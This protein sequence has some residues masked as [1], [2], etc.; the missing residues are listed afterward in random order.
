M[1]CAE[2]LFPGAFQLSCSADKDRS[3]ASCLAWC[4]VLLGGPEEG[5]DTF[6]VLE[7][8]PVKLESCRKTIELIEVKGTGLRAASGP[9]AVDMLGVRG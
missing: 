5:Q 8:H 6:L 3:L 4:S 9:Y 7:E 1:P 2:S